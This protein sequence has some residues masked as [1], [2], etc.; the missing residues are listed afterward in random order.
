[1]RK[2][3]APAVISCCL[4]IFSITGKA[5]NDS[6]ITFSEI[7]FNPVSGNNEFIELY[8]TSETD[9]IDLANFKIKYY[10]SNS[11]G[12]ISTGLGTKIPPKGFAVIFE[13]D[14]DIAAG[15]YGGLVPAS[16]LVLKIVD[17]SFGTSGMANTTDRELRLISSG[18]DTLET[19]LYS[20]SNGTGISDEKK[21]LIQDNSTANWANSLQSNGTPG[22][23]NSVAPMSINLAVSSISISPS[24]PFVDSIIEIGSVL[25]NLGIL[26]RK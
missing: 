14:Y 7:M 4:I 19:Y 25:K 21:I 11:D 15:I 10:T 1:M 3:F 17:N 26:M 8:N 16:A 24:F 18:G 22:F 5:Q 23:K 20:S 13:G 2:S 12:L 6:L 9:S